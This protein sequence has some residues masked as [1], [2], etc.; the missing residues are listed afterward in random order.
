MSLTKRNIAKLTQVETVVCD[1]CEKWSE[2]PSGFGGPQVAGWIE[3]HEL[4]YAMHIR[5]TEHYCSKECLL[6]HYA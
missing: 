2:K 4:G 3:V 5:S 6:A 1:N